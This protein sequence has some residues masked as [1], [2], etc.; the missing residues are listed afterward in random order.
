MTRL[1]TIGNI[2]NIPDSFIKMAFF[3]NYNPN[4]ELNIFI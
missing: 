2:N 1:K 4:L 3:N